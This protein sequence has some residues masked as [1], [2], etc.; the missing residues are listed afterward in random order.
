MGKEGEGW[1]RSTGTGT[2]QGRVAVAKGK[3][4]GNVW[5]CGKI[6]EGEG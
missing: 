4:A 6:R 2:R 3:M 1:R 5:P